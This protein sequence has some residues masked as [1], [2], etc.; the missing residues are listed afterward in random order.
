MRRVLLILTLL[1]ACRAL[2][3]DCMQT[4][5]AIMVDEEA[6]AFVPAMTPDR[7]HA[8]LG[9]RMI[10]ITSVERI[11]SFRVLVLFDTSG[12]ME[13]MDMPFRYQHKALTLI[14]STFE[15]LLGTLPRSAKV[16][17]GL[18]NERAVF[19]PEFTANPDDL[20]K[21]LVQ[22]HEQMKSRAA[23]A[24]A[25]Y[26][27]LQESLARFDPAQPGDSILIVTDGIDNGSRL[28]AG[29]VQEEASRKSVR[30]FS[31]LM[32]RNESD[33][34]G[35]GSVILDFAQ[36]TGGSV[37]V[38]DV[39]G[40]SWKGGNEPEQER[41]ELRRFWNNEVLSGYLL[42][43]NLPASGRK[44][45]KW[46]LSVDRLPGQK[47]KILAAYPSRL[48]ACPVATAAAH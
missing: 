2:A 35:S 37:H 23:K 48:N 14:N 1:T 8:K 42:R 38:I 11:P 9:S 41:Q 3:Q 32:K 40:N 13:H 46:L 31:I 4:V 21:S 45:R 5:P 39:A 28:R 19:G 10:P 43:F 47:N 33:Y 16:E 24:T 25:L 44:Q 7:L 22:L 18:F 26:D 20:R 12:S 36:R 34:D 15:E 30:I 6:R 29:K 17:Y 27:A